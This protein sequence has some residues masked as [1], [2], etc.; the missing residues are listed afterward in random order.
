LSTGLSRDARAAL[1]QKPAL[2]QAIGYDAGVAAMGRATEDERRKRLAIEERGRAVVRQWDALERAYDAAE[3]AY[4]WQGQRVAG[5]RLEKF[6]KALKAD[7]SL[8]GVL[9]ERGRELGIAA[10]SRLERVVQAKKAEIAHELR[11][12]LGLSQGRGLSLG[13]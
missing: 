8:D 6:A 7:R 12:E 5:A 11:H 9:R 3:K 4:D 1:E 2:A 10:G 13:M